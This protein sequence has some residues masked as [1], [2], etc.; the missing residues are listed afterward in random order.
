[1][2]L[3]CCCSLLSLAMSPSFSAVVL[4]LA[5]LEQEHS[6]FVFVWLAAKY[7]NP[8]NHATPSP[9]PLDPNVAIPGIIH[10]CGTCTSILYC[11][12]F[13]AVSKIPSDQTR[14]QFCPRFTK[15]VFVVFLSPPTWSGKGMQL[16]MPLLPAPCTSRDTHLHQKR[17]VDST[18]RLHSPTRTL[19]SHH[20]VAFPD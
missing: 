14:L 6:L 3:A 8:W 11:M 5:L 4:F 12:L 19:H 13:P 9:V 7:W 10:S 20:D 1:M 2:V 17:E 15:Y 16:H 18:P